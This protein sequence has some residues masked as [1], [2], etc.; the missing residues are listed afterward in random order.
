[1]TLKLYAILKGDGTIRHAKRLR[2]KARGICI[3]DTLGKAKNNARTDGD[4]V[5][6][7]DVDMTREPVFIRSKKVTTGDA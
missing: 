5:I 7:I 3:Y 1:M 6:V 4:S 2:H